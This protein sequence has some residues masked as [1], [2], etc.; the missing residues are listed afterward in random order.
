MPDEFTA[1][2]TGPGSAAQSGE[3]SARALAGQDVMEQTVNVSLPPNTS[4]PFQRWQIS[5]LNRADERTGNLVSRVDKIE[6]QIAKTNKVLLGNG[7]VGTLETVRVIERENR[8]F[9]QE[10]RSRLTILFVICLAL[11]IGLVG[12]FVSIGGVSCLH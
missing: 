9:R 7:D 5:M 4:D 1:R 8:Y 2:D 12:A 11:A 6:G 3:V 10:M